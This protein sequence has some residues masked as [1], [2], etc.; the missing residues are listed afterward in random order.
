M[1]RIALIAGLVMAVIL[2]MV[3]PLLGLE[4][5]VLEIHFWTSLKYGVLVIV[6]FIVMECLPQ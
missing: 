4:Q 1:I 2:Y 3:A 6:T 5:A